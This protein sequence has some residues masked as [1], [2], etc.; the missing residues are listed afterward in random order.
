MK[1]AYLLVTLLLALSSARASA[2]G[3]DGP[4][5][6]A[7]NPYIQGI[8]TRGNPIY[9][10]QGVTFTPRMTYQQTFTNVAVIY[11]PLSAG[12]IIPV[13]LQPWLPLESWA[14][15]L[16]GGY[17][18]ANPAV[19]AGFGFNLLDSARAY[20]SNLLRLSSNPTAQK[21]AA[22]ITPGSGPANIYISR[23]ENIGWNGKFIP[24]WFFGASFGF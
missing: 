1:K 22:Q 10:S 6:P 8:W 19:G 17:A 24:A 3:P 2:V 23:Q 7:G 20:A 14:I 13:K 5:A 15:T 16:G 12:S 11:H 4:L 9:I 18:G 21:F